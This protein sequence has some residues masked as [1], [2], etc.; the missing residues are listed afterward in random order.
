VSSHRDFKDISSY[1]SLLSCDGADFF[2]G[3]KTFFVKIVF[4]Q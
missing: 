4:I 2:G 1:F 3:M